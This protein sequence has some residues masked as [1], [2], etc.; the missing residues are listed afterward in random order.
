[1]GKVLRD[2]IL[3]FLLYFSPFSGL[4]A[5]AMNA[6]DEKAAAVATKRIFSLL[7]KK[8]EIDSL[9]DKGKKEA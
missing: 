4:S 1:M 3:Q 5:V 6:S 8:C 7:D 9:S 2:L